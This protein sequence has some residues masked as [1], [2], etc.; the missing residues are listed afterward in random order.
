[1]SNLKKELENAFQAILAL[2]REALIKSIEKCIQRRI[3]GPIV[4]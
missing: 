1:M 2:Y 4:R 3:A